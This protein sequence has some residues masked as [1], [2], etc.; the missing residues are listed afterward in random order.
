[1][2]L[3]SHPQARGDTAWLQ[4]LQATRVRISSLHFAQR[5]R[6]A[7]LSYRT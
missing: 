1:M 6:V 5:Y 3:T 4:E 2:V 7:A